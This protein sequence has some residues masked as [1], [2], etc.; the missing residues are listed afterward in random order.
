MLRPLLK[1]DTRLKESHKSVEDP[2]K[3]YCSSRAAVRLCGP[4]PEEINPIHE[5]PVA[6]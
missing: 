3:G 4:N 1:S 2:V 5:L 6:L